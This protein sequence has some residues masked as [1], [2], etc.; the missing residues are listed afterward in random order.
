MTISIP[1]RS[2][3]APVLIFYLL[4]FLAVWFA[5]EGGKMVG[6]DLDAGVSGREFVWGPFWGPL[7]G[8]FDRKDLLSAIC[9]LWFFFAA[10]RYG[11][12]K[13]LNI[14]F[15]T[16]LFAIKWIFI[17]PYA[18][19]LALMYT[20]V[21]MQQIIRTYI[22]EL[23]PLILFVFAWLSF[24]KGYV[25]LE[26]FL[27]F[28]KYSLIIVSI[29]ILVHIALHQNEIISMIVRKEVI[30][31]HYSH[32]MPL[33]F[34]ICYADFYDSKKNKLFS[35]NTLGM[36]FSVLIAFFSLKRVVWAEII[37]TVTVLLVLTTPVFSV[38]GLKN[39][40]YI[41]IISFMVYKGLSFGFVGI[42]G[43]TMAGVAER[44]YS[45][46]TFINPS[47]QLTGFSE[48]GSLNTL[49]GHDLVLR[50][51]FENIME[52]P[53]LGH[54]NQKW[55]ELMRIRYAPDLVSFGGQSHSGHLLFWF[56]EGI[57]GFLI[58]LSFYLYVGITGFRSFRRKKSKYGLI[59]L[60]ITIAVFLQGIT[61]QTIF[62]FPSDTILY[63]FLF[64]GLLHHVT[65]NKKLNDNA[66]YNKNPY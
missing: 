58:Y 31:G 64:A 59:L 17:L 19:V 39:A 40:A 37:A 43:G 10:C 27:R 66:Y 9:W 57:F 6:T 5:P 51:T 41:V 33:L 42:Y 29:N 28:I 36:L 63:M 11:L 22:L 1:R 26:N 4:I 56:K 24:V 32:L 55:Q 25:I 2:I 34:T 7:Y 8:K 3:K 12:I 61:W 62:L 54:G 14:N 48:F 47:K 15:I 21:S 50:D 20:S 53:I 18:S 13:L 44:L 45:I 49:A 16:K 38:K 30:N 46:I 23:L 65:V 60:A 35:L 52:K